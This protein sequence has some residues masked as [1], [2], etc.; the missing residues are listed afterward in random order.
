ML[1]NHSMVQGAADAA[2]DAGAN[3]RQ[4]FISDTDEHEFLIE[5]VQAS[6]AAMAAFQKNLLNLQA[7]GIDTSRVEN[8]TFT[9]PD[10]Y[11][12]KVD[13]ELSH[14]MKFSE[15][16]LEN[17]FDSQTDLQTI[18]DHVESESDINYRK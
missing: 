10:N 8:P 11:T 4:L 17:A 1:A 3:Q 9:F 13:V 18:P 7:M 15:S 12:I 6:T 2:A 5:P 16:V 14:D